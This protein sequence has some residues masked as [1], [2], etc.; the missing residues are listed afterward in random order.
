MSNKRVVLVTGGTGFAGSHLIE[1]LKTIPN[2]EIH[3]TNYGELPAYAQDLL[4]KERFHQVDLTDF[5]ATAELVKSLLPN[6]IYHL[7]A[8]ASTEDSFENASRVMQNNLTLQI[9][10]LHAMRQHCSQ[11][12]LLSIGSA[13]AY[14]ES[15]SKEEIPIDESHP[16]R[17]VN[18]YAVSK[19]S[20]ELLARA[21]A[22]SYGLHIILARPFNH[23]GP[24]QTTAFAIP[25]FA[26]QLVK[27]ERGEQAVVEVGNLSA[28]RDFSDVRDVVKAYTILMEKGKVGEAY[29]I[30]SGVGLT[31]KSVLDQMIELIQAEVSIKHD[32]GKDRPLDIPVVIANNRKIKQLGWQPKYSLSDTLTQVINYWRAQ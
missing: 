8:F 31:V 26:A 24:R 14:G 6:E 21:Y 10:L 27:I 11:A 4:P 29:N 19:V 25:A 5:D 18:P 28:I 30:G 17:P 1:E 9:N 16:F 13:D 20:Q 15:L 12:K 2:L 3:A 23:L 32:A 22:R 7:A